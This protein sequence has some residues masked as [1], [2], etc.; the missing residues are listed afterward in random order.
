MLCL[1]VTAAF[2]AFAWLLHRAIGLGH[3]VYS[4]CLNFGA[5]M[6]SIGIIAVLQPSLES[7]WFDSA[8]VEQAGR[9]YR[10]LGVVRFQSVLRIIGWQKIVNAPFRNDLD[11]LTSIEEGTRSSELV[12]VMC[13][14]VLIPFGGYLTY[15]GEWPALLYLSLHT[16]LLQVYP[17]MLQRYNRPRYRRVIEHKRTLRSVV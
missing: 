13:F 15:L 1:L 9:L 5:M 16:V 6:W 4:F 2:G 12:H 7:R 14:L 3:F 10:R 8:R 17:I 11:T